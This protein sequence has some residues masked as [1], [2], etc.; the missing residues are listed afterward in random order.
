MAQELPTRLAGH[1]VIVAGGAGAV[2]RGICER[3]LAEGA[4]V[5]AADWNT[6]ALDNVKNELRAPFSQL[7]TVRLDMGDVASIQTGMAD[8]IAT[9]GG[10]DSAI[11]A[12]GISHQGTSFDDETIEGWSQVITVNL[13]GAFAFAKAAVPH[14]PDGG[15]IVNISSGGA[16]MGLPLNLAYGASKGGLRNLTFGLSLALA[17]RQIRV[18]AVGPG[19][20]EFP[21]KNKR[22]TVDRREGRTEQVPLGRLGRG[23]DIGAAVAYLISDDAEWVTGQNIYVDGGALAK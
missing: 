12:V 6:E 4:S 3:L 5:V 9:L 16:E 20:M 7:S 13:T 14:M 19:L 10:L 22:T 11:N 23:S 1:R 15:A 18:N 17:E 8:A 2:G 21:M